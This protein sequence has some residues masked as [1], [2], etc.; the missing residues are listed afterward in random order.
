MDLGLRDA[1]VAVA[2]GTQGMGRAAAR[3]LASDRARIVVLARSRRGIEDTVD[4]L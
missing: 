2:E 4:E 1:K 3:F